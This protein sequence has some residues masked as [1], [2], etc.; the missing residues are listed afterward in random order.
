VTRARIKYDGSL[1][2]LWGREA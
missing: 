2:Q 1:T